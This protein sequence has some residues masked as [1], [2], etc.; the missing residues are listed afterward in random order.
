MRQ[1]YGQIG[2]PVYDAHKLSGPAKGPPLRSR[3]SLLKLKGKEGFNAL[4]FSTLKKKILTKP[5]G[6]ALTKTILGLSVYNH[7]FDTKANG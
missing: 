6:Q 2:N 7:I 1:H 4:F 5:Q 3:L